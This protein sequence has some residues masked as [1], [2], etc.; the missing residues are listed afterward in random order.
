[1]FDRYPPNPYERNF[2]DDGYEEETPEPDWD[3]LRELMR[4]DERYGNE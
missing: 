2:E 1:M 4:D 3:H